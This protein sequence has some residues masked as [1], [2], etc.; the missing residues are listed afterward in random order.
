[1]QKRTSAK[2]ARAAKRKAQAADKPFQVDAPVRDAIASGALSEAQV[3]E[4]QIITLLVTV[5]SLCLIEG[6]LIGASVRLRCSFA[7]LLLHCAP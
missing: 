6:L 1:M 5:F 3:F 4:G 2:E 7:A